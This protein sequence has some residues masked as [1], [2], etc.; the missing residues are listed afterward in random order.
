MIKRDFDRVSTLLLAYPEGF[1]ETAFGCDYSGLTDFYDDLIILVPPEI[2]VKVLVTSEQIGESLRLLRKKLEYIVMPDLVSIWLR[3]QVGFNMVENCIVKP[4]FQPKFYECEGLWTAKAISDSMT[5]LAPRLGIPLQELGLIWDGGNMVTNGYFALISSRLL[6][7]NKHLTP[8]QI[9]QTVRKNL[10]L[11]PIFFP[12]LAGDITG[13]MDGFCAF[14]NEKTIAVSSYPAGFDQYQRD[15]VDGLAA[16]CA[17]LGLRVIR[18]QE[19]PMWNLDHPDKHVEMENCKGL[20]V[21][22][23]RL[24]DTFILPEYTGFTFYNNRNR[25]LLEGYGKVVTINCDELA[26]FGGVLHCISW[27]D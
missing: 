22:F 6:Q 18:T 9:I 26:K 20:Y 7:D 23:L 16:L 12:E 25:Q 13:H 5:H 14:V 24:N 11:E 17:D 3:D 15:Y 19:N 2:L 1:K 8:N 4:C 27:V 21:N 10:F